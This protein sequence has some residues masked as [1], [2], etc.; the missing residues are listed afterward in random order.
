MQGCL[1]PTRI[2][3]NLDKVS[4]NFVWGSTEDHKKLH[5]VGWGKVTKPKHRGAL[6]IQEARGRNLS[7]AAKLCWHMENSKSGGWADVLR[8]KYLTGHARKPKAHTRAWNAVR[9]GSSICEK[10]SKWIVGCSSSLS[11]WNDK[12]LNI[13]TIRFLIEGPL[14]IGESEVCIREVIRDASWVLDNLSFVFPDLILKV[15]RATPLR[16]NSVRED[17]R[18]WISSLNGDFDSSNAYLLAINE[19]LETP[20]FHGKWIWKL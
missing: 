19:N 13:G 6:G 12:W 3:N 15:V 11:F 4:R 10:G 2:L 14:N 7:L 18:S 16:R 17:H 8:K 20:D 1:L 9:S 5:M